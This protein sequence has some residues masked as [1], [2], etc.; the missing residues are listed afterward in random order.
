MTS[1]DSKSQ[2]ALKGQKKVLSH[3]GQIALRP[4]KKISPILFG[5]PGWQ[6]AAVVDFGPGAAPELVTSSVKC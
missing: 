1:R 6:T 4:V 2:R 3:F 5:A